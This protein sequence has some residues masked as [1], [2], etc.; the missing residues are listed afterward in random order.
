MHSH[1]KIKRLKLAPPEAA[2]IALVEVVVALAL[3]TL[4][5]V[6]STQA[7]VL[8]NRKAA[9][10]R[11]LTAARAIVQRN[12]DTALTVAWTFNNEPPILALTPSAG[13]RWDDDAPP[14]SSADGIVQIAVME[15]G[16][17]ATVPGTLTRTVTAVANPEGA[18][19]R[20]VTFRIDYQ[21][22]SHPYSVQMITE[23]AID[24]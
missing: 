8:A 12:V 13:S 23:R 11:T 15:D 24:D 9:G 7:L 21:Y 3:L 17:T 5:V 2:G 22:L 14:A 10:M 18:Q 19:V 16:V 1:F 20:K 4:M 6:S